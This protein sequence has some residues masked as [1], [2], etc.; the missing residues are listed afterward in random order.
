MFI[1]FIKACQFSPLRFLK[2]SSDLPLFN[3]FCSFLLPNFLLVSFLFAPFFRH[4]I[5]FPFMSLFSQYMLWI[6]HFTSFITTAKS[7]NIWSAKTGERVLILG[8]YRPRIVLK[9]SKFL[10][11]FVIFNT[12]SF[13]CYLDLSWVVYMIVFVFDDIL[14]A[15]VLFH[16]IPINFVHIFKPLRVKQGVWRTANHLFLFGQNRSIL[17]WHQP[18]QLNFG[19][20]F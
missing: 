5:Q 16:P 12:N 9:M 10:L 11:R 18:F 19:R 14:I 6:L 20:S 1:F 2:S 17:K 8:P 15:A 7:T 4:I 13:K 3:I